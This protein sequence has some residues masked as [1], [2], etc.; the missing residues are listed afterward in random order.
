M[1]VYSFGIARHHS[2]PHGAEKFLYTPIRGTVW[3]DSRSRPLSFKKTS[4]LRP[5]GADRPGGWRGSDTGKTPS[6]RDEVAGVPRGS[7][8]RA[9]RTG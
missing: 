4:L 6:R 9:A 3:E 1:W 5:R 2:T 7:D 8:D